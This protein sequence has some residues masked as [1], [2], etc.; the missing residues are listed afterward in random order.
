MNKKMM[1]S[2][3]SVSGIIVVAKLLGFVRQIITANAFGTTIETD[4]I[5]LGQG[6]IQ[7]LD[8]VFSQTLI[9]SFIPIYITEKRKG[10]SRALSFASAILKIFLEAGII[11]V[12]FLV[13]GAP[14]IARVL[15][16]AY[17][18]ALSNKLAYYVRIYA[19]TFILIAET[20]VFN[21][22]L[23]ANE[24]FVTGELLGIYQSISF[25]ACT[26]LL[27][28]YLK[29]EALSLAFFVYIFASFIILCISSRKQ[30]SIT[31]E[32]P[33]HNNSV[34]RFLKT[35]FIVLFGYSMIFVNQQIDKM[36]ASGLGEGVITS[37]HY[38]A[39]LSNF[40][41]TLVA[42]MGGIL[43][44]YVTNEIIVNN[45]AGAAELI[46]GFSKVFIWLLIPISVLTWIYSED[47]VRIVFGR[48]EF[49]STAIML[50]STALRG[51][52]LSFI[53][54]VVRELYGRVLYAYEDSKHA[55]F[56][57]TIAISINIILSILMSRFM[58]V[59]GI[60]V[61]SSIAVACCALF[62]LICSHKKNKNIDLF[63]M[64]REFV[65]CIVGSAFFV[66]LTV[67][68]KKMIP[69]T[70]AIGRLILT[71]VISISISVV[72]MNKQIRKIFRLR[73]SHRNDN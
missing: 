36:I 64:A 35:T 49:D 28:H 65:L 48:G 9:T 1:K 55:T 51:Y 3:L 25:I 72:L 16:P 10:P 31:R 43:F 62:N 27:S 60:T 30:W 68:I 42:S 39:V 11:I 13:I 56:N 41:C 24:H 54:F 73:L 40:V 47:I 21:A 15:A 20:G 66:V 23:K 46:N 32:N 14:V 33:F 17:P 63:K 57:S 34:K 37:V 5:M 71:A 58:G 67:G 50:C 22:I 59:L 45:D 44:T 4:I 29:T 26:L 19:P 70:P 69:D 2:I 53:P 61:A 12:V 18:H 52:A 7:D 38:A 6:I 8:F